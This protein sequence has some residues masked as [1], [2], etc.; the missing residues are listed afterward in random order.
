[1]K[2]NDCDIIVTGD[3]KCAGRCYGATLRESLLLMKWALVHRGKSGLI[4]PPSPASI[5]LD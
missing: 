1:M 2:G 4:T 3:M 5:T